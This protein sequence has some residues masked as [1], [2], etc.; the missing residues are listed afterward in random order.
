MISSLF[1]ITL[2]QNLTER[3]ADVALPL[4][5]DGILGPEWES[6]YLPQH[7]RQT[8]ELILRAWI[9]EGF[10]KG[11]KSSQRLYRLVVKLGPASLAAYLRGEELAAYLTKKTDDASALVDALSQQIEIHLP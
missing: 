9:D 4:W 8:K 1:L 2:E 7:V 10:A 3:L 11:G 5:C 6:D